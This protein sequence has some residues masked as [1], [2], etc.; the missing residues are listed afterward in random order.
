M[1]QRLII[2]N[3]GPIREAEI[4]V[5]DLTV[6]VG[7]QATG[8]SLAAQAL[9]FLSEIQDFFDV[10][11]Q[12]AETP[13]QAAVSI[14][15]WWFGN[16]TSAYASSGTILRW[17][18]TLLDNE[19]IYEIQWNDTGVVLSRALAEKLQTRH[20]PRSP[21]FLVPRN[22]YI[23]GGRTLYSFVPPYARSF[24]RIARDWP[25]YVLTFYETLGSVIKHLWELQMPDGSRQLTFFESSAPFDFDF[26]RQRI[27]T[28]FKGQVRYGP[29]TVALNIGQQ[30]LSAV[31]IASGQMEIWPLWAILEAVSLNPLSGFQ[32][33]IEEPEAH[34]HP[35]AQRTVMEIIA[36][37]ASAGG[38]FLLTTHSPYI[39]YA[40]NNFLMA[41]KVLDAG[42]PLP[43]T[44][45][46]KA[47]LHSNEVA[48]YRF[49]D[50]GLVYDIMDR[51]LGLIDADE[52]DSVADDLG[53]T[54]TALQEILLQCDPT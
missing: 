22:I 25:G 30:L 33:C 29:D 47:A 8:K 32:I 28:I 26:C 53:A 15:E 3:F 36:H 20:G 38:Q 7:P 31:T 52:L 11:P 27:E 21:Y 24:V 4:E 39:V 42:G 5:R 37:L 51:E 23:P 45:P 12:D 1:P 41:Q 18:S 44:I 50:D 54:F 48:A 6:F 49:S 46:Q 17:E 14:M 34:L 40:V 9:F 35:N 16:K 10:V 13:T 43:A 19:P 2:R